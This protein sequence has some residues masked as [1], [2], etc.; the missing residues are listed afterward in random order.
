M[1]AAGLEGKEAN[2]KLRNWKD[3]IGN[4]VDF[5]VFTGRTGGTYLTRPATRL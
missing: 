5:T 1:K 3:S 2:D 4:A